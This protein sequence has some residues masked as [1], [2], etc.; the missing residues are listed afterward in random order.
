MCDGTVVIGHRC[1]AH[2]AY[3]CNPQQRDEQPATWVLVPQPNV[4][5][6]QAASRSAIWHHACGRRRLASK[7]VPPPKA[8][9]RYPAQLV[10]QVTTVAGRDAPGLGVG[11]RAYTHGT[12]CCLLMPTCSACSGPPAALSSSTSAGCWLPCII[13]LSCAVLV[14]V[15]GTTGCAH[16]SSSRHSREMRAPASMAVQACA[17]EHKQQAPSVHVST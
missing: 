11:A 7:L 9:A 8:L 12:C 15:R 17:A 6:G 5:L 14:P 3:L 4:R 16:S 10:Q 13:A 1:C 2:P